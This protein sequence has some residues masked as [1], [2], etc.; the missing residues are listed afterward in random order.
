MENIYIECD[1]AKNMRKVTEDW[2]RMIYDAHFKISDIEKI[3]GENTN[4]PVKQLIIFSFNR[5]NNIQNEK[6]EK[7]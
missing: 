2:V 6:Q 1:N 5:C 7:E 3:F 4:S